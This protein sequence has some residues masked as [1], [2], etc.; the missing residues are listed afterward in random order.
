M[1]KKFLKRIIALTPE[2]LQLISACCSEGKVKIKE[3]KYLPKNKIFLFSINRLNKEIENSKK[4]INSI[5]KF[6]YI[7]SSKS[8]NIDQKNLDLTLELLAIDVFKKDHEY[9]ITLLF[10]N[11][12]LITL[13]AEIIEI[14]MEDQKTVN[15]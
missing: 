10:S 12:G 5:I 15:D 14:V 3:I 9:E 11:N 6:G 1:S 4:R 8:K 7:E 2:D 13:T